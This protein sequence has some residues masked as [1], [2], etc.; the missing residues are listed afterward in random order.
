[1]A[2]DAKKHTLSVFPLVED[3]SKV[4]GNGGANAGFT[5]DCYDLHLKAS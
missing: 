3:G 5:P 2:V 1:V 4:A